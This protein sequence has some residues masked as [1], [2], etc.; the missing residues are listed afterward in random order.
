MT[1]SIEFTPEA[2][3][4]FLVLPLKVRQQ[5]GRKIDALVD[6]PRPA[7]CRKLEG[8]LNLYRIR[9]GDYRVVYEIKD[10]VLRV[11]IIRVEHRRE[12]YR[13]LP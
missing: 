12:V 2:R 4:S 7:Q 11:V 10:N 5:I 8:Q 9:S 13:K 6:N 3:K 1:Y